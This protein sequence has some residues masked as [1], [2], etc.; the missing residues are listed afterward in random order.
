MSSSSNVKTIA[1]HYDASNSES[2]ARKLVFDLNPEWELSPG[3]VEFVRFKEGITN[4]VRRTLMSTI[5]GGD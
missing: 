4:T 3:P 2:S 5:I 1:L